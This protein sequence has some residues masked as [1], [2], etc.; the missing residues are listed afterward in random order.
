MPIVHCAVD[1]QALPQEMPDAKIAGIPIHRSAASTL[2]LAL[3][4]QPDTRHVAVVAGSTLGDLES[5]EQFRR[6]TPAFAD[7]VELH[8]ANQ[9]VVVG[10]AR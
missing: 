4:L 1:A 8:L 6:E 10:P 2:E 7:R 3:S 9:P 5:A